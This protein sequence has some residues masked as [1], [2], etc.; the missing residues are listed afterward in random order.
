M[1]GLI[2]ALNAGSSSIKFALFA[3]TGEAVEPLA[4]GQVDGIGTAPA[5][6]IQGEAA[7]RINGLEDAGATHEDMLDRILAWAEGEEHG[8]ALIAVGHRIV[9][10]GARRT[11]P[12]LLDE[13]ELA[14]LEALAP[15][16]PLHQPHN[17]AAV[18]AASAA[19][20]G[21]PQ[22]ACFDTAFHRSIPDL[23]TRFALPRRFHAAGVRR[24]GF[25]GL[26]Y[27]YL[28]WRLRADDPARA[29]GRVLLAHLGNGASLCAIRD[30]RS[31]GTSMGF[32][33]LDGLMMGTRCGALDPGVVLHLLTNG[34]MTVDAAANLLNHESG[35]AGVSG[36]SSDMRALLESDAPE[37]AEAI[38]LFCL[39]AARQA[40]ALIVELGGVDGIVFSGGIGE[41]AAPVRAGIADWLGWLGLRLDPSANAR[42]ADVVST[43]DSAIWARV[44]PTDEEHMIAKHCIDV[45]AGAEAS[46]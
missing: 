43:S 37:A 19:R 14:A 28:T 15:L 23:S 21:V 10:G 17:L 4:R 26:S 8:G 40:G 11:A 29:G 12:V 44:I 18:R 39:M 22:I 38:A 41:H 20:P 33:A 5:F 1:K 36:L 2:L 7:P 32:T 34:G 42:G 30:G 35:L 45:L 9:H 31:V 6:R 3:A 27:E 24:Y 16:A 13:A 46:A 25:H